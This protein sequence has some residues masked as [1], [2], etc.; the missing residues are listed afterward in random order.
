MAGPGACRTYS[1][2]EMIQMARNA[3]FKGAGLVTAV[4]VALAES[5]GQSCAHNPS[6]ATG[7]LQFMP[8]TAAGV[9]LSDPTDAQASFQAAYRLSRQGSSWS[10]WQSYTNGSW[11]QYQGQVQALAGPGA[12]AAGSQTRFGSVG[13]A[14]SGAVGRTIGSARGAGLGLESGGQVLVGVLVLAAGAGLLVYLL[15]TRTDVGR[16]AV[17]VGRDTAQAVTDVVKAA[18]V[19]LE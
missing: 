11:L 18:A 10:D 16:G 15:M 7:I 3:G 8:A 13:D 4:A 5:G 12:P 14:I 17:R 2:S 19:L 9:G 6:G 1:I